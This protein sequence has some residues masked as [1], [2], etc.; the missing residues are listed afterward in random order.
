MKDM[1]MKEKRI[2]QHITHDEREEDERQEDETLIHGATLPTIQRK[3]GRPKGSTTSAIGLPKQK[4][5]R[6]GG[7]PFFKKNLRTR[8]RNML[9]WFVEVRVIESALAGNLICETEVEQ[10]PHNLPSSLLE[11]QL[12]LNLIKPFFTAEAWVAVQSVIE[13]RKKLPWL[14]CQCGRD[15]SEKQSIGCDSCMEWV[16][17][18]CARL[19]KVPRTKFWYCTSCK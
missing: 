4:K 11:P 1:K 16:H 8:Q 7:M 15:I 5:Q 14:C 13:E 2:R 19:K 6:T 12:D 18:E 10:I 17:L 3:R 9:A